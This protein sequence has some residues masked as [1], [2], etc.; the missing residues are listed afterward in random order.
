[1]RVDLSSHDLESCTAMLRSVGLL[2]DTEV[3][4]SL[5]PAGEGNMNL[6]LRAVVPGGTL[7]VK[8]ARDWVEKYPSIAAP[9]ERAVVEGAFYQAVAPFSAI[10]SAMPR[11]LASNAEQRLLVFED[12]GEACDLTDLYA[13]AELADAEL[14]WLLGWLRA[15]HGRSTEDLPA[16]LANRA[17]RALNHEHLFVLP[18]AADNGLDLDALVPGLGDLASDVHGDAELVGTIA[19]WGE[20]YLDD[21]G[22]LLHGDFYP[23]SWLRVGDGLAVIDPEFAFM[24]AAGFDHGVLAGHLVLARQRQGLAERVLAS[25]PSDAKAWAG[26]EILRRLLGV[27]QLPLGASLQERRE[28]IETASTWIREVS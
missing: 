20:R 28:M 12:L 6:T 22:V 2:K 9:S 19:R 15:L 3:V 5:G 8:Q 23:G 10:A 25:A 14:D 26:I 11:L 7:I 27:A 17:M 21:G 18:F 1:M 13:S 4:S 24:G 16:V